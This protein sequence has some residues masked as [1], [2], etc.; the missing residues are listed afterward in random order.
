MD[1]QNRTVS[2]SVDA[3]ERGATSADGTEE[4]QRIIAARA[5]VNDANAELRLAVR[6]AR[7]TGL[8]WAMIGAALDT[9]RCSAAARPSLTSART[10]SGS[11]T[12]QAERLTA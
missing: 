2:A 12:P 10:K 3:P 5:G 9:S 7:A 8:S 11:A 4:F 1:T 6:A